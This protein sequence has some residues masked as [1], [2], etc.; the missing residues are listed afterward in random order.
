MQEAGKAFVTYKDMNHGDTSQV[1]LKASDNSLS[2][3]VHKRHIQSNIVH[4]M[5]ESMIEAR[6]KHKTE[7]GVQ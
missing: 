7:Q 2:A 1:P 4:I 6:T 5:H 3:H